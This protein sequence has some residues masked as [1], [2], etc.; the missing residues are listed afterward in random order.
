MAKRASGILAA[1]LA[2]SAFAAQ[3]Q[4][5]PQDPAPAKPAEAPAKPA[6]GRTVESVTV[7]GASQNGFRS[8]ID[9][10]SYGIASDLQTT[11][12]SI[13][14]ALRNIPS[15]E[16]DPQGNVSLRGD[17]N[18][19]I[20]LDGKPSGQ[21]KGA[22]AGQA[23]Q[24]LPADSIE[25]V[26]VITNPSAEFSP[27]GTAGIINLIS[28]KTRKAGATG[29][30]RA[31]LG[32]HG[33]RQAGI[34][35]AYNSEK[36]ALS[37]D[38][39]GRYDPQSAGGLDTREILDGQGH[40]LSTSQT[41]NLGSGHLDRWGAHASAD[42]DLDAHT[43]IG[44]DI[45][46]SHIDIDQGPEA[47]FQAQDPTGAVI[48]AFNEPGHI[49]FGLGD[50]AV[51][52]NF[53]RSFGGDDHTL[54]V[55][56]SREHIDDVRTESFDRIATAPTASEV[57]TSLAT[58]NA[59]NQS[60]L[61]A[62]YVR[63]MPADGKLK[64]GYD[65]RLDDNRYDN[66]GL[67]G[68]SAATARP[69]ATQSNLFL[70]KQTV[71]AAYLTY[72]QPAGDWTVLGGLRL[73]NVDL[74]L[75][76]VTTGEAHDTSYFR[77]YPS[78]HL[79]YKLPDAQQLSLSY[80]RRVQRPQ[81]EDLNP[82]PVSYGPLTLQAGNP[83]LQPQTTDSF[84]A[85]YQYRA[86]G[87]F[88]LATLYYRR[89]EH[90]VTSVVTAEPGGALL[91]TQANLSSS[92]AAGLELVANGHL[93]KTLSY[94][95]S[96]NLYWNEIDAQSDGLQQLL[97]FAGRRSAFEVGGRAS[98]TWQPTANDT[99]QANTNLNAKRLTP[100]G[101]VEPFAVTYLGYR[102]KFSDELFG[103]VTIQDPFE[104]VRFRQTSSTPILR[105]HSDGHV[106]IRGIFFGVTRNFGAGPKK[107]KEPG[108]DFGG[109]E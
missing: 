14:D 24:A 56:L 91:T 94:S 54:T 13:S 108:F 36:L 75:N 95:L 16:V 65:L 107:P 8:E 40:V 73:E 18:V 96:T 55:N 79:A 102:H 78:L 17:S 49:I 105:D 104:G 35:A 89:N 2:V 12:G 6:T 59:Q 97:D 92:Q 34:T 109:G 9:R 10:K 38:I 70:Y 44:G 4:E 26:E 80:S 76:Q 31:S 57:F 61:K 46:F 27:E 88:Y 43:R 32:N 53:R 33:R 39:N 48:Q 42:Y 37:G 100:Q 62:D 51:Q 83:N 77:A 23:L 106:H 58:R 67:I 103:V 29:S 99:F 50:G 66:E 7:T 47:I 68:A 1:A 3:A 87:T 21:F 93:T 5:A 11:T 85:G 101:F 41:R 30:M 22:S 19:T 86:A 72:E 81:P 69:D 64:A 74:A 25:R 45:R 20:L 52:A 84:E 82:F 15:V 71:A 90:G 63:P 98:L 28:K 60:E